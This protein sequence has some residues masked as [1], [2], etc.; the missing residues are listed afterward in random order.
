MFADSRAEVGT[1]SGAANFIVKPPVMAFADIAICNAKPL[2][3]AYK[4][5]DGG[6]A[7]TSW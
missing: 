7:S 6:A 5:A 3:R 1:I 4:I 2:E